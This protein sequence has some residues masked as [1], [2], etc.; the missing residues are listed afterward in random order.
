VEVPGTTDVVC[1]IATL[2]PLDM[3]TSKLLANSDRWGDDG[4][5]SR[6]LID[7]AMMTPSLGL[8]R[9]AV[10]KAEGAYGKSVLTDLAKAVHRVKTRQDWLERCMQVMTVSVPKALLWK[11]I[12]AIERVLR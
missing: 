8:L 5:F 9:Q 11:K 4:A 12:Q 1:G 3:A 10:V 6:D 2:T 7:L